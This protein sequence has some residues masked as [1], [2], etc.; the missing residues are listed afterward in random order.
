MITFILAP[1]NLPFTIALGIMFAIGLLEG[2]STVLGFGLSEFID[3]VLPDFDLDVDLE[4]D[5]DADIDADVDMGGH[6]PDLGQVGSATAL[7][8]L[9]GW[10]NIGRVPVLVLLVLLLFGFG[11]TGLIVQSIVSNTF[12]VLLPGLVATL[13]ALVF[14]VFFMKILGRMIARIVPKEETEAVSEK[15]FIGRIAVITIGTAK[16][17]KPAQGKVYDQYGH[18]HYVMIEPDSEAACF[19]TG[20]QVLLVKQDGV[21]FFAIKNPKAALVDKPEGDERGVASTR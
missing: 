20:S 15:S 3:S 17:G 12:G 6:G 19:E 8:R 18:P 10:M 1:Q 4:I 9:F 13:P 16:C 11:I 2:I 21:R 7:S 5:A 14:G